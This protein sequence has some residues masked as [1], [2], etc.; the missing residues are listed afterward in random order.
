M[1]RPSLT[2]LGRP[3]HTSAVPHTAQPALRRLQAAADAVHRPPRPGRDAGRVFPSPPAP[4]LWRQSA[5]LCRDAADALVYVVPELRPVSY[6]SPA[7]RVPT[8]R[9]PG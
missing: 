6:P 3:S 7:Y 8:D 5:W 9:L 2:H 4:A 1:S